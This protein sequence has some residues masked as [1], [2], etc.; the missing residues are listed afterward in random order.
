MDHRTGDLQLLKTWKG[1]KGPVQEMAI[2]QHLLFTT[3]P[4]DKVMRSWDLQA[5]E[6]GIDFEGHTKPLT[7]VAV[8][9][10]AKIPV[11]WT[12]SLDSTIRVWDGTTGNSLELLGH[13][14]AV[15]CIKV[16]GNYIVSGS[17]D[18]TLRVWDKR[19]MTCIQ[20]LK[21]HDSYVFGLKVK[22]KVIYSHSNDGTVIIWKLKNG[23]QKIRI[24]AGYSIIR[25]RVLKKYIM[26]MGNNALE[27][28]NQKGKKIGAYDGHTGEL[29]SAVFYDQD[30]LFSSSADRTIRIWNVKKS[31]QVNL[32]RGHHSQV[33][34]I[35][36]WGE[37]I[38]TAGPDGSIRQWSNVVFNGANNNN[39]EWIF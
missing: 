37:W 27:V 29:L 18:T 33:N 16:S 11:V 13:T 9:L 39:G 20:V 21:G 15:T 5:Q 8:D 24:E 35:V 26:V 19:K 25:M 14:D 7:D 1:H 23:E 31:Q 4:R 3:S 36:F 10:L 2:F 34:G 32:Y 38:Y 22:D 17:S 28:Y 30:Y 6:R 12:A